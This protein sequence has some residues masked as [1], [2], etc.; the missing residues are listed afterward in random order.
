MILGLCEG[1]HGWSPVSWR[2]VVGERISE[3][4]RGQGKEFG[5]YSKCNQQ[6]L[7][8]LKQDSDI[9]WLFF[10]FL[11]IALTALKTMDERVEVEAAEPDRRLLQWV[12]LGVMMA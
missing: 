1:Q 2:K 8:D 12:K 5:L 9:M 7:V 6:Q 4:G 11:K 10:F 3:V